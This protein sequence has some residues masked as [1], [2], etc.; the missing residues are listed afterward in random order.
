[1]SV[2]VNYLYGLI[3]IGALLSF[4]IYLQ[5]YD[6]VVPC[7]LCLM[8]RLVMILLGI[9]FILAVVLP[10]KRLGNLIIGMLSLFVSMLGIVLAGRQ[11][12]LQH[13]PPLGLDEC[14]VSLQYM[15]KALPM[16]EVIM[17]AFN[18][19]EECTRKVWMFM[20]LSLAEWSLIC[21]ILFLWFSVHQFFK[22]LRM[23]NF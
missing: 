19:S 2:R 21:F 10:W 13:F 12:W 5:I 7:P 17:R 1:M 4:A 9:I 8:Q 14:A 18:G 15:V 20:H 23:Q 6:G 11:V 16:N 3:I 22:A